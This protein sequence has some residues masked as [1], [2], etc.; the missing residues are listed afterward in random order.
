MRSPFSSIDSADTSRLPAPLPAV[1]VPRSEP[2]PRNRVPIHLTIH[3]RH[4]ILDRRCIAQSKPPASRSRMLSQSLQIGKDDAPAAPPMRS[5]SRNRLM[6][7]ER[8]STEIPSISEMTR[9]DT[10]RSMATP[11]S[12]VLP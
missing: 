7:R 11:S 12:V 1:H 9:R 8:V 6:T 3:S 5:L 2:R 10:G 4:A